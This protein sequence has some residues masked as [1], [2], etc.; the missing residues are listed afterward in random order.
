VKRILE[1]HGLTAREFQ[2]NRGEPLRNKLFET[3]AAKSRILSTLE[4]NMAQ[5]ESLSNDLTQLETGFSKSVWRMQAAMRYQL[6]NKLPKKLQAAL[7]RAD[8][9]LQNQLLRLEKHLLPSGTPQ[10]R[11][12]SFLE[13]LLKF[14]SVVLDRVFTL[15]PSKTSELE[16]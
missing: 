7:L 11:H 1:K 12:N 5:I 6:E 4:Q 13:Y 10:E 14:G 15:E 16:I 2:T 3:H 9:D 8:S